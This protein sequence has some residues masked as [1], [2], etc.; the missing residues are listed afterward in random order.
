MGATLLLTAF[1]MTVV[2]PRI[3]MLLYVTF[4]LAAMVITLFC[5]IMIGTVYMSIP[6][7]NDDYMMADGSV[8][9][10]WIP[11]TFNMQTEVSAWD[12][13]LRNLLLAFFVLVISLI[14]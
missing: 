7:L 6:L 8:F 9:A 10:D 14:M 3:K 5:P 11:R 1:W 12:V 2:F 13:I 4:S